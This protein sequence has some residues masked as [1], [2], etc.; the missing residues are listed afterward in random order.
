MA[1]VYRTYSGTGTFSFT[2]LI[3]N[4]SFD[5]ACTTNG[6]IRGQIVVTNAQIASD[7][8][9]RLL[10]R[11]SEKGRLAGQLSN[12]SAQIISSSIWLTGETITAR[13]CQFRF[14]VTEELK[15]NYQRL[16]AP[17]VVELQFGLIN[18]VFLGPR[19]HARLYQNQIFIF[20][21]LGQYS[22]I[23]RALSSSRA[24]LTSKVRVPC[25]PLEIKKISERIYDVAM[26]LSFASGTYVS[27]AYVD[28]L[29]SGNLISTE[30]FHTKV[31][32]YYDKEPLIDFLIHP[33]DLRSFLVRA[34]TLYT[35]LRS[36]LALDFALEYCVL[37]K[38]ASA[39]LQIKFITLFIALEA[40]VNRLQNHIPHARGPTG[41]R[42]SFECLS[43]FRRRRQMP[44]LLVLKRLRVA[45]QY[46]GLKDLAGV[47][48]LVPSGGRPNYEAIRNHLVHRGDFPPDTDSVSSMRCLL[49]TFQ[50]L[51]LAILDY[52]DNYIDCSRDF[53]RRMLD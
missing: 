19:F 12:S 52:R 37:A 11:S 25:R 41:W 51:L 13:N 5:L 47:A 48:A 3:F 29:S 49:D 9:Q 10:R 28:T 20:E 15:I 18:F 46:Y 31:Y 39:F 4:A 2:G 26:L 21:L 43:A 1:P 53:Q 8:R 24:E 44:K 33:A 23:T 14:L 6:D 40:L 16:S 50:R 22:A 30:V 32:D 45:L 34:T 36:K 17:Y 38:S 27:V 7:L 35:D 42:R